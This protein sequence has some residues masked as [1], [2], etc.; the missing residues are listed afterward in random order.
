[1]LIVDDLSRIP[2]TMSY[3][4]LTIGVFDGVHR[5][6]QAI[7]ESLL[8]LA[9]KKEGA[10]VVLTFDPHPQ[11]IITPATAP[12][13]LQTPRQKEEILR[14]MGV[15]VLARLPFTRE[16]SLL[17][18][19]RFATEILLGIHVRE[20]V[21]GANFRFGHK[22]AG[23]SATLRALCESRR[24]VVHSVDP[25]QFRGVRVSS[26]L[27]RALLDHGRVEV[28]RRML[29]RPYQ[30]MGTVVHGDGVGA[31]LGFPTANIAPENELIP[32][33]GVYIG[34]ALIGGDKRACLINVGF[35]PTVQRR[36]QDEPVIEA[37]LLDFEGDVYDQTISLDFCVRLRGEKRFR[38]TELLKKQVAKD[39]SLTR[40]YLAHRSLQAIMRV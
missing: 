36:K 13:L 18:P 34:R 15:A 24:V 5:G 7:L 22:R 19:E 11:R 23:D 8:S 26:T 1:M 29:N 37:H 14:R 32:A 21:L 31:E 40:Q 12:A 2:K 16:M 4:V 33:S 39:I 10:S 28:A 20:I 35:R 9:K 30:V 6:H 27:I 38:S 17:S 25:V 3:P